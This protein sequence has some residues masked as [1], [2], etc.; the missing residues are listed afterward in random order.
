MAIINLYDD[1]NYD[2]GRVAHN[3][4][5]GAE[6]ENVAAGTSAVR[7]KTASSQSS[8]QKKAAASAPVPAPKA[9]NAAIDSDDV[10]SG[11][12]S[13]T[14]AS[15]DLAQGSVIDY[16]D[17]ADSMFASRGQIIANLGLNALPFVAAY[18]IRRTGIMGDMYNRVRDSFL[19][20]SGITTSQ[21]GTPKIPTKWYERVLSK[22]GSGLTVVRQSL[23]KLASAPFGLFSKVAVFATYVPDVW[24]SLT[25]LLD[26]LRPQ[27]AQP[28]KSRITKP[29]I[30]FLS[31]HSFS[32]DASGSDIRLS[33]DEVCYLYLLT[34]KWASLRVTGPIVPQ[35]EK[36][37]LQAATTDM[38]DLIL[39]VPDGESTAWLTVIAA[40]RDDLIDYGT[41]TWAYSAGFAAALTTNK[42]IGR[43][44]AV[45]ANI[46]FIDSQAFERS[47]VINEIVGSQ[48]APIR[49]EPQPTVEVSTTTQL[50]SKLKGGR[51]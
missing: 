37:V 44:L 1:A 24:D 29:M 14:A 40:V 8:P 15:T 31:N 50:S 30:A 49:E 6:T 25:D 26:D 2:P 42:T 5:K 43:V 9:V 32:R 38:Q 17:I 12:A 47:N 4:A 21:A 19:K 39:R 35:L 48:S 46:F 22:A 23:G 11:R 10:D 7:P 34:T 27:T 13:D 18:A 51:K 45:C 28:A 3:A 41:Q 36:V 20:A 33:L 16:R